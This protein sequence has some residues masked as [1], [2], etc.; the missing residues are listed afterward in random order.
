[1]PS[2]TYY[3]LPILEAWS[4][5]CPS[6]KSACRSSNT[7]QSGNTQRRTWQAWSLESWCHIWPRISTLGS[8]CQSRE[9]ACLRIEWKS[10]PHL[11]GPVGIRSLGPTKP[12]M[13]VGYSDRYIYL[14]GCNGD[15]NWKHRCHRS[16][17]E[18]RAEVSVSC[19]KCRICWSK[20][21]QSAF[22]VRLWGFSSLGTGI[23]QYSFCLLLLD[24]RLRPNKPIPGLWPATLTYSR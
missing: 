11:R 24:L 20:Y 16:Y 13:S 6:T 10:G 23:F 19:M 17:N 3:S 5:H 8:S 9:V 21:G 4:A 2:Q 14:A 18:T 1:M 22:T 12:K 15:R 7:C